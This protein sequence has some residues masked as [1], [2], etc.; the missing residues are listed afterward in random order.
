[1][2]PVK[3]FDLPA[4]AAER[5]LKLFS[6]QSGREV[7]FATQAVRAAQTRV[8]KGEMTAREAIDRM[9]ADT[10]LVV[11][12]D[13]TMDVFS[14]RRKTAAEKNA[15]KAAQ[16]RT[17]DASRNSKKKEPKTPQNPHPVKRNNLLASLAAAFALFSAPAAHAA[18]GTGT[19]A[20]RVYNPATKVYV[21]S[22]EIRVEGT[23][24]ATYSESDGSF[25]LPSVPAGDVTLRVIY[26]GY[27]SAT[28]KFTVVAGRTV[29]REIEIMT[30]DAGAAGSAIKLQE[31]VVSG[32]REGNAKAI[33]EQR[34]NM[35]VSTSVASDIFGDVTDGDVGEFLKFLPG[36]DIDYQEST[37]RG[38]RLGGMDG[39]YVGVTVDGM[40]FA[41]A[42]GLRTGDLGR[43]TSFEAMSISSIESIEISRTTS[44]DMDA[45]SPAGA[46]NLKSRRAFDRKGR[47]LSYNTSVSMNSEEFY[48]KRTNGPG[49][50]QTYKMHPNYRFEYS[51]VLLKDRLGIVASINHAESYREQFQ[52]N[53]TVHTLATNPRSTVITQLLLKDGP[54][55]I[56]KDTYTLTADF[57]AT[58]R[59]VVSGSFIYNFAESLFYNRAFQFRAA[60]NDT[61]VTTGRDT[62]GGDGVTE[63]RAAGGGQLAWAQS[64]ASKETTTRTI[65]SKFEYNIGPFQLDGYG[66]YSGSLNDYEGLENGLTA[67]ETA[68]PIVSTFVLTRPNIGS[69]QWTV[70]QLSGPDWFNLANWQNPRITDEARTLTTDIYTAGLNLR[71]TTP[72]Q[73][74]PTVLKFGGK[75][76]E[77]ERNNNNRN[78]WNNWI[79]VGPGG[80]TVSINSSSGL[81]VPTVVQ[82]GSWAGFENPNG[83]DGGSIGMVTLYDSSGNLRG[84][85][86]RVHPNVVGRLF[87]EHPEN[88][89]HAPSVNTYFTSFI[90]NRKNTIEVVTAGYG[91]ADIR[92]SSQIQVRTGLRWEKTELTSVEFDPL[93]SGQMRA[94][95]HTLNANGRATTLS[96]LLFQYHSKPMVERRNEY[97]NFF[98]MISAKYSFRPDLQFHLGYNEAISRPPPDSLTG[99]WNI[100]DESG[101]IMAANSN[102]LPEESKNFAARAAYYFKPAGQLS[103]TF[104][105]NTIRNQRV[106]ELRTAEEFGLTGADLATYAGYEFQAPFN[107]PRATRFRNMEFAYSQ[108][109]PFESEWLRGATVNLA[110]SRSYADARRNNL[111][112]HRF[113]GSLGYTFRRFAARTGVVWRDD[114]DRG[115]TDASYGQ[116]RRHDT[117]VDIAAEYRLNR[118][119]TL[120]VTGRNIFNV[121]QTWMRTPP[122]VTQGESAVLQQYENY[123]TLWNFG[124][125]GTF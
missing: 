91:M 109:L 112:P 120:Y 25:R 3:T 78:P 70:R 66:S 93:S 84:S 100:N 38:P 24:L 22:A 7:L 92:L 39:Q 40:S 111:L 59:L 75:I 123:G 12:H 55:R 119:L 73:R 52:Q 11:F 86:P 65:L 33:M 23:N 50:E 29:T 13:E 72:L 30:L 64:N 80:N 124:I 121:G 85:L 122:G 118:R 16:A 106:V 21:R 108:S 36:V 90:G 113:T 101:I 115:S 15:Q 2:P 37:A 74:I 58:P 60:T 34:R 6:E 43:Q 98:R 76:A 104:S 63:I 102:L 14:V 9:L 68:N 18:E 89:V 1:M 53:Q 105:Q 46:V 79:Y 61:N 49:G 67:S 4:G 110:Y 26:A 19:I 82:P 69:Y 87:R 83:F 57:K 54:I 95:G 99:V 27:N 47:R 56:T 17:D 35:N 10:D 116:Y 94:A 42:D 32:D 51:D 71:W 28:A 77:E 8:V 97:D 44:S 96:G 31:F 20:G 103:L 48:F 81:P 62:V 114:T 88:F 41:S 117:M 5:S 125:K 107:V 45:N